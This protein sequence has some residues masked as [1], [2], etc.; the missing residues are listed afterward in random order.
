MKKK[1]VSLKSVD[2]PTNSYAQAIYPKITYDAEGKEHKTIGLKLNKQQAI[3]LA[4]NLLIGAKQWDE[5]RITAFRNSNSI[6]V[7]ITSQQ[8]E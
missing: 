8:P 2:I 4:T 6:S 3:D 7:T 1:T 5:M